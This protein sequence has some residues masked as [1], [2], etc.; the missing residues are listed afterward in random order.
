MKQIAVAMILLI[1]CLACHEG[2]NDSAM[3]P[4]L[5]SA[6]IGESIVCSDLT[7]TGPDITITEPPSISR[8]LKGID[9]CLINHICYYN[10][11]KEVGK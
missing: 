11:G 2:K 10:C 1:A 3:V 8:Q 9:G 4:M 6:A 5:I 7:G